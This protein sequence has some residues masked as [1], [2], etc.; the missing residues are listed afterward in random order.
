MLIQ[1]SNTL[2]NAEQFRHDISLFIIISF[3]NY[4]FKY[5]HCNALTGLVL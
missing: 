3:N 5:S 1:P 2:K 4:N